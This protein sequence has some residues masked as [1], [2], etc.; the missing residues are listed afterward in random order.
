MNYTR[1]AGTIPRG[2]YAPARAMDHRAAV[3]S[4]SQAKSER[5]HAIDAL[6]GLCV[7]SMMAGHFGA[8]TVL[9]RVTHFAALFRRRNRLHLSFRLRSRTD[10]RAPRLEAQRKRH[11]STHS[12]ARGSAMDRPFTGFGG[13]PPPAFAHGPRRRGS[14]HRNAR[15]LAAS[16][17]AGCDASPAAFRPRAG[18]AAS[19]H[20]V[21]DLLPHGALG[22]QKT[23]ESGDRRTLFRSL[24]LHSIPARTR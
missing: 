9:K 2:G 7:V 3:E 6:R 16:S 1:T 11:E 23:S 22:D 19:L 20:S 14:G 13:H 5:N 10:S 12:E 17:L 24:A 21:P 18:R 4:G 15:R 8:D